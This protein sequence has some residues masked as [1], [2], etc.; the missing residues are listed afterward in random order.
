MNKND[1]E[2]INL[3]MKIIA[4]VCMFFVLFV[5]LACCIIQT[6]QTTTPKATTPKTTT[7]KATTPKTTTPKATTPKTTTDTKLNDVIILD[8]LKAS[9][10]GIA[11]VE[12]SKKENTI[13]II[14]QN[15][16]FM[17]SVLLAKNGDAENLKN[18]NELKKALQETSLNVDKNIFIAVMNNKN[19]DKQILTLLNGVVVYDAVNN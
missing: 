19:K 3:V 2:S 12:Y 11:D 5:L 8:I 15:K 13:K 14:P 18:W 1:Y 7:P 6:E 16:Y 17:Y 9:Y 4:G 10:K